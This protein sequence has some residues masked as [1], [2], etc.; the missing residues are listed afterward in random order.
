MLP[1][2]LQRAI[3]REQD[4]HRDIDDRDKNADR[5]EAVLIEEKIEQRDDAKENEPA[6]DGTENGVRDQPRG[7]FLIGRHLGFESEEIFLEVGTDKLAAFGHE[8]G[9]FEEVGKE[10]V[11][12]VAEQRVGVEE[13]GGNAAGD[14]HVERDLIDESVLRRVEPDKSEEGGDDEFDDDAA[15]V[16]PESRGT[17]RDHPGIAG[18]AVKAGGHDKQHDAHVGDFAAEVFGG[19]PVAELV[20]DF[21]DNEDAVQHDEVLPAEEVVREVG[22]AVGVHQHVPE[23]NGDEQDGG[24][25]GGGA[26]EDFADRVVEETE[27]TVGVKDRD[28]EEEEILSKFLNAFLSG[29]GAA[30]GEPV[31]V[32][33]ALAY[34]EVGFVQHAHETEN[35][36]NGKA[37]FGELLL[38]EAQEIAGGFFAVKLGDE[39]MFDGLQPEVLEFD[40]VF[41]DEAELAVEELG[42]DDEV[43]AE[44]GDGAVGGFCSDRDSVVFRFISTHGDGPWLLLQRGSTLKEQRHFQEPHRAS[45]PLGGEG[46]AAHVD[47]GPAGEAAHA[48]ARGEAGRI[49]FHLEPEHVRIFALLRGGEER[50]DACGVNFVTLIG[51]G[52][53]DV[54]DENPLVRVAVGR[55]GA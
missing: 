42:A 10:V 32:G 14:H 45:G 37:G 17:G 18:I 55:S 52:G 2:K 33:K 11:A 36:L 12:V 35:I 24:D 22:E 49:E 25:A 27:Q 40:G 41:H 20:E 19:K 39:E 51:P 13:K 53:Q 46:L 4:R 48:E 50:C 5:T 34:E 23:G 28:F 44:R 47:L 16:D 7:A 29:G 3:E 43:R 30:F 31:G 38:K 6:I 21:G 54:I 1:E 26:E 9:D 15:G 8:V